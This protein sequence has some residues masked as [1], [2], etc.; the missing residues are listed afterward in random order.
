VQLYG[1]PDWAKTPD[2]EAAREKELARLDEQIA[3]LETRINAARLPQ[4]HAFVLK[5]A[6]AEQK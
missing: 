3:Q 1:P 5:P 4:P 2:F 6:A